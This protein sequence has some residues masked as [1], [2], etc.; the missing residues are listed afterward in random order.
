MKA[1]PVLLCFL[2][3]GLVIGSLNSMGFEPSIVLNFPTWYLAKQGE[4]FIHDYYEGKLETAIPAVKE[5]KELMGSVRE[6]KR[7]PTQEEQ[8]K[9]VELKEE[10]R[11]QEEVYDRITREMSSAMSRYLTLFRGGYLI[12]TSA[13]V[14]GLMG[15]PFWLIQRHR[16]ARR[17]HAH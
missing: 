15:A 10:A 14:W 12:P 17:E 4:G 1:R 5:T 13:M 2:A 3:Y 9:L 16:E 11:S 6:E 8:K 7:K